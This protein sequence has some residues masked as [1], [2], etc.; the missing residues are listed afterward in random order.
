MRY[1]P[2]SK[3]SGEPFNT[4]QGTSIPPNAKWYYY[5]RI[6]CNDCAGRLYAPDATL[7]ANNFEVH[8]K[9]PLHRE[10]VEQRR[11]AEADS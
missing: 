11:R 3:E 4:R 2:V 5:P 6:R 10:K 8:L 1:T 9:N 7:G